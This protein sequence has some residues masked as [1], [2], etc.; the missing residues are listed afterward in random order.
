MASIKLNLINHSADANNS[1]YVIFQKN[2]ATD[3]NIQSVAWKVVKNLGNSDNHPFEYPM[4]FQVCAKDYNGNYMPK[5]TA[6][7]DHVYEVIMAQ[8]GHQLRDG[9][10]TAANPNEVEVWNNLTQGAI[11]AQIYRDGKLLATKVNV[12][13]GSK[14]NFEFKPKI[15]IGMVS[16]VEEGTVMNSNVTIQYLT[17]IDLLGVSSADIIITGGGRGTDSVPFKFT[18]SNVI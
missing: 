14:A 6:H 18:L 17:E 3:V 9:S 10:Q 16:Q 4:E 1:D 2:A 7:N 5:I 8:S 12:A 13:P 15:F 11:D